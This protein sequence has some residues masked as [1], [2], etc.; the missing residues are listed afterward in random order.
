MVPLYKTDSPAI[1]TC[2]SS[3]REIKWAIL[4]EAI[5]KSRLEVVHV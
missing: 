4:E 1:L 3:I 5:L 2:F